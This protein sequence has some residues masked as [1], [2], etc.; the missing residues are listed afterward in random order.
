MLTFIAN[1]F[2]TLFET[3]LSK[4]F[5]REGFTKYFKNIQ[6]FTLSRFLTLLFS[7]TTTAIIARVL[8]PSSFGI[9]NY[10]LSITTVYAVIANLGIDNVVYKEL[11]A[12]KEKREEILGSAIALKSITGAIAILI[13]LFTLFY[14]SETFYIKSLI[15]LFSLSF[16][17]QPL[18]L[19][20][21]DF[22]KDNDTKYTAITQII[23]LFI[24]NTAKIAVVYYFSSLSL[25][26]FIL[27]V[28]NIILGAIYTYQ[29]IYFKKRSITLQISKKEIIFLFKL[30]L[31]LTLFSAFSEIYSRVDQVMLKHYIDETAVGLYSAAVR[32][33]DIW[34]IV[35]SIL[36]GAL[37]PALVH[38]SNQNE[39]KEY[40]K[41]NLLFGFIFV[42]IACIIV[43]STVL[44]SEKLIGF[45]Y[46]NKFILA[47]P[48]LSV[49]IFS[50]FGT[51]F[52]LLIY[53]ELLLKDKTWF[54]ILLPASTAI[55]NIFLNIILIPIYGGIGAAIA[56]T[57]SYNI[58]PVVYYTYKFFQRRNEA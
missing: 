19:L 39:Q 40:K 38:A 54:I 8:G 26:I 57:F 43:I 49:Y 35:P 28:E 14:I 18:T 21:F 51:F 36:F 15:F 16:L 56:T 6:W 13:L 46:G 41:R 24:S 53:Q 27:V 2:Y 12:H 3:P 32:L 33:T 30:A 11:I 48:I 7:L 17:T 4:H 23:T 34:N 25:L 9:F 42:I 55:T 1:Y 47:A 52:M 5:S 22:L 50:L 31:P 20:T 37:F 29:V 10:V 45:V 44:V 58:T